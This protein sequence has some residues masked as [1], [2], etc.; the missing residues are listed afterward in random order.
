MPKI[1]EMYC[2]AAY[3]KDENDEGIPSIMTVFGPFPLFGADVDR[4]ETVMP[5]AQEFADATGKSLRIYKFTQK[6]QIGEVNPK[7]R[8]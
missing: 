4:I 2:F 6:E 7:K 3:D 8:V 1:T 5:K